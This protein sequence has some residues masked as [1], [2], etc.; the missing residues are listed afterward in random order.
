[1]GRIVTL[2]MAKR[3]SH[4]NFVG[5]INNLCFYSMWDKYYVRMASSLTG[6]RVK[7]DPRFALTRHYAGLMARASKIGSN[8]YKQLPVDFRQF[9]MY[10]AFTGETLKMLKTGATDETATEQ[11]WQTYVNIY[12]RRALLSTHTSNEFTLPAH[13]EIRKAS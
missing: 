5:T 10:R 9:W 11:L 8:I 7:K 1:M 3:T 6:E 13:Y 12:Y 2:S 4:I